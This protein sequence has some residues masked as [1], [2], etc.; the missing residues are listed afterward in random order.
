MEF[1]KELYA[2]ISTEPLT[3]GLEVCRNVRQRVTAAGA[4]LQIPLLLEAG[5][6]LGAMADNQLI[7]IKATLPAIVDGKPRRATEFYNYIS[8]V[9]AELEA[10][11]VRDKNLELEAQIDQELTRVISSQFGYELTEGDL[12][13]V[14][15]LLDQLRSAITESTELKEDH[16]QRLLKRLEKVQSELHKK[17]STLDSLYCFAIEVSVAAGTIGRNAEPL[18]RAAKAIAGIAWRTHGHAEGLPSGA[19]S[20]LLGDDSASNL[21]D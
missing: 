13:E 3:V 1:S 17:L 6:I 11:V 5:K 20:P 21:L 18:A 8:N 15:T 7:T 10:I 9:L 2:R 12:K 19:I 14:Q 16:K 4:D